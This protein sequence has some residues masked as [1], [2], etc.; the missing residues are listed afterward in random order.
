MIGIGYIVTERTWVTEVDNSASWILG[1]VDSRAGIAGLTSANKRTFKILANCIFIAV[2]LPARALVDV[3]ACIV[4]FDISVWTVADVSAKVIMTDKKIATN[5]L[6][7]FVDIFANAIVVD[8]AICAFADELINCFFVNADFCWLA[9][10]WTRCF[11]RFFVAKISVTIV[12]WR[13][14]ARIFSI[15]ICA[16]RDIMAQVYIFCALVNVFTDSCIWIP[17]VSIWTNA[18]ICSGNVYTFIFS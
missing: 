7:A 4:D 5:G 16:D 9:N 10:N 3:F 12:S 6:K 11:D 18:N 2:V 8:E 15:H 17:S 14:F 1:A 13:A